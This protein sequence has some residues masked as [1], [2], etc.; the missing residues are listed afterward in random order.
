LIVQRINEL[1]SADNLYDI[2][3]LPQI[4]LHP[5]K[6][7]LLGLFSLDI[8]HPYRIYIEP[9]NGDIDELKT[10]TEVKVDRIYFDPH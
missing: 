4:R 9:Q 6:G 7:E 5:L 2:S 10:V 8:R 1:K 3:K